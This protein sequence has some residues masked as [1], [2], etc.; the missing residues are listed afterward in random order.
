MAAE[1][2]V[3]PPDPASSVRSA[4]AIRAPPR[5]LFALSVR[6][7]F[8]IAGGQGSRDRSRG[9]ARKPAGNDRRP[10]PGGFTIFVFTGLTTAGRGPNAFGGPSGFTFWV[11]AD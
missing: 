11:A 6:S 1:S 7:A 5:A 10:A 9:I 8:A 2:A 3:M 4:E